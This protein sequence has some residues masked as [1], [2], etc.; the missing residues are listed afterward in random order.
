MNNQIFREIDSELRE[1]RLKNL[2]KRYGIYLIGACVAIVV[3]VASMQAWEGWKKKSYGKISMEFE[4]LLQNIEKQ[5]PERA[6]ERLKK[7]ANKSPDGYRALANW[8]IANLLLE[9]GKQGEA[10]QV[11]QMEAKNR[12]LPRLIRDISLLAEVSALVDSTSSEMLKNKLA[13]MLSPTHPLRFSARDLIGQSLY[14]EGEYQQSAELYRQILRERN[15]PP[16]LIRRSEMMLV[17]IGDKAE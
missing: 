15:A 11:L 7:F 5:D 9:Q 8:Q 17:L 6:I 3:T 14:R 1:E 16:S 10:A 4:S 2:W 12:K 13:T